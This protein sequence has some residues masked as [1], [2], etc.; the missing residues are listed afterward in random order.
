MYSLML[1]QPQVRIGTIERTSKPAH[2]DRTFPR[3]RLEWGAWQQ[4]EVSL[5]IETTPWR[6]PPSEMRRKA[7]AWDQFAPNRLKLRVSNNGAADA[8]WRFIPYLRHFP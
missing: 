1:V 7:Q 5:G 8:R 2:R 3:L 4:H 6:E